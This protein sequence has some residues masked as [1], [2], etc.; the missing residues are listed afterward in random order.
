MGLFYVEGRIFAS[1]CTSADDDDTVLFCKCGERRQKAARSYANLISRLKLARP[2][3]QELLEAAS[4]T[5]LLKIQ[6][7]FRISK[8]RNHFD[9]FDPDISNLVPLSTVEK[10]VFSS[11]VKQDPI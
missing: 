9:R 3:Y 1:F 11:H 7:S 2:N 8:S 4:L 5:S 10:P 6:D